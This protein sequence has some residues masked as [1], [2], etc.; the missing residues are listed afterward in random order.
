MIYYSTLFWILEPSLILD[1]ATDAKN[2]V[3]NA[4]YC[5][6]DTKYG[7]HYLRGMQI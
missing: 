7:V 4:P 2:I 5:I 6:D 3:N 1:F